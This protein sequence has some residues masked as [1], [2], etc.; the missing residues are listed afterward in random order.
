VGQ[1]RVIKN[2]RV[3]LIGSDGD[4]AAEKKCLSALATKIQQCTN[5]F[6]AAWLRLHYEVGN[7]LAVRE[8]MARDKK[9]LYDP[10]KRTGL[11]IRCP[12]DPCSPEMNDR[13]HAIVAEAHPDCD[14]KQIQVAINKAMKNLI[15]KSG[16]K[17]PYP[18][19]MVVLCGLG[20]LP[21]SSKRGMIPFCASD[22][23]IGIPATDDGDW[24]LQVRLGDDAVMV[25]KI[26]TKSYRLHSIRDMLWK[27]AAK[28]WDIKG[29]DLFER[30]GKWYAQICH[31]IPKVKLPIDKNKTAFLSGGFIRPILFRIN[32]RTSTYLRR[33]NDI[34]Y[35][36]K[37]LTIQRLH[38]GSKKKRNV[39]ISRREKLTR[40][41][42]DFVKTWN[43]HLAD[44]MVRRLRNAGVGRLVVFE[45]VGDMRDDRSLEKI[46]RVQDCNIESTRWDWQQMGSLIQKACNKANIDVT[47]RRIGE[48]KLKR[49][50]G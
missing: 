16:I 11:R 15:K 49:K 42:R 40:R 6:A 41:W 30:E 10:A 14:T 5:D 43:G 3:D 34:S 23:N 28:E 44:E 31:S 4:F 32:G 50:A 33:G 19:W 29:V 35:T 13:L 18:R 48:R 46:G 39:A 9:W 2:K 45:P 38:E 7:H 21:Q 36:R 27:I 25:F 37:S 26:K 8:W 22:C 47:I 1:Y 17:S 20:E 12:V 24:K